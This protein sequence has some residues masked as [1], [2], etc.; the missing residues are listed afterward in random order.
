MNHYELIDTIG[1]GTYGVV[2]KCRDKRTGRIVAVKQFKNFQTNAYIRCTMLR[3]LRV[4]QLLKGEPNVTQ[5]LETFK[6]R[7]RL[8]LVMEYIPRSLL[9][10]LEEFRNGVP[11]GPLMV[12]L[13]TILLGIQ[14][15][16]RNGIIHRDV[17]PE[18]I[19]VRDDGTAS[20]CDFGFCR[21]ALQ[22]LGKD[23]DKTAQS[24]GK[25]DTKRSSSSGVEPASL[26][27]LHARAASPSAQS[28]AASA[29]LN[30]LVLADHRGVMTDYVATRWYRSPEML[31]GMP[32]YSYSVDMWAVGAIMAEVIDGEPL[33]PGK[34]ELEQIALIQSRIGE[35]PASYEAAV[36]RRNGG[37]LHLRSSNPL[38]KQQSQAP[39]RG[40]VRLGSDESAKGTA[41]DDDSNTISSYL[42]MRYGGR[43]RK[44]GMQLLSRLLCVDSE[45]RLTVEEAL[46]H[47]Y[48]DAVRR[49][50][51]F[52]APTSGPTAPAAVKSPTTKRREATGEATATFTRPS[53]TS[54]SVDALPGLSPTLRTTASLQHNFSSTGRGSFLTAAEASMGRPPR[55]AEVDPLAESGAPEVSSL[56]SRAAS[57]S[58]WQFGGSS[59]GFVALPPLDTDDDTAASTRLMSQVLRIDDSKED[60]SGG[61]D[62]NSPPPRPVPFETPAKEGGQAQ[63]RRHA[64]SEGASGTAAACGKSATSITNDSSTSGAE[65]RVSTLLFKTR[66]ARGPADGGVLHRR[67]SQSEES[68]LGKSVAAPHASNGAA[69]AGALAPLRTHRSDGDGERRPPPSV[70][71]YPSPSLPAPATSSSKLASIEKTQTHNGGHLTQSAQL[72]FDK[73]HVAHGGEAS[74]EAAGV[75]ASAPRSGGDGDTNAV[76]GPQHKRTNSYTEQ[77]TLRHTAAVPVRKSTAKRRRPGIGPSPRSTTPQN[78]ITKHSAAAAPATATGLPTS[79]GADQA[80]TV[81]SPSATRMR[82]A[83]PSR[84]NASL[85]RSQNGAVT[86]PSARHATRKVT[87]RKRS[88]GGTAATTPTT[89]AAAAQGKSAKRVSATDSSRFAS[90]KLPRVVKPLQPRERMT[91][92]KEIESLGG[93]VD[94]P[95]AVEVMLPTRFSPTRTDA[96]RAEEAEQGSA[97]PSTSGSRSASVDTAEDH[98]ELAAATLQSLLSEDSG[99]LFVESVGGDS[100]SRSPLLSEASEVEAA[101]R[102]PLTPAFKR[103]ERGESHRIAQTADNAPSHSRPPRMDFG[104]PVNAASTTSGDNSNSSRAPP[105]LFFRPSRNA[106]APLKLGAAAYGGQST[107]TPQSLPLPTA[108]TGGAGASASTDAATSSSAYYVGG[109]STNALMQPPNTPSA[110]PTLGQRPT[111]T[112]FRYPPSKSSTTEPSPPF[113]PLDVPAAAT[114]GRRGS[115]QPPLSGPHSTPSR[116]PYDSPRIPVTT[117]VPHHRIHASYLS[118]GTPRESAED[119]AASQAG[120][121]IGAPVP[122]PQRRLSTTHL[123]LSVSGEFALGVGA[124]SAASALAQ[125][126]RSQEHLPL[127]IVPSHS[128]PAV[129]VD[130]LETEVL[131]ST[132]LDRALSQQQ[133]AAPGSRSLPGAPTPSPSPPRSDSTAMRL[134]NATR[135]ASPLMSTPLRSTARDVSATPQRGGSGTRAASVAD[136]TRLRTPSL[137]TTPLTR[138]DK[139]GGSG[140]ASS[141]ERP[142]LANAVSLGE[143][144]ELLGGAQT[145]SFPLPSS[146]DRS[147]PHGDVVPTVREVPAAGHTPHPVLGGVWVNVDPQRNNQSLHGGLTRKKGRLIL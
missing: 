121:P 122:P 85:T 90:P 20:L 111:P 36:R 82:K 137:R 106:N 30:E 53:A 54:V 109:A 39:L 120:N 71:R 72:S 1:E 86:S 101:H 46:A 94:T 10:V 13:Y 19:L 88:S 98:V 134:S 28:A 69:P 104:Y 131:V 32:S 24:E 139:S 59:H 29:L 129:S 58:T 81:T 22:P 40:R 97:S 116:T 87:P 5:L 133:P 62:G 56:L 127:L 21:P 35:F 105:S 66:K 33:L 68:L 108:F 135:E 43:I 41:S 96:V 11:E 74:E 34:T 92:L 107:T 18:N 31:L 45:G 9:D 103:E 50:P 16:H 130:D 65:A 115:L 44:S 55:A 138:A 12:L 17:K 80:E 73:I 145:V 38:A 143:E 14:S 23:G 7:N 60:G 102:S 8:Y 49:D 64:A 93:P 125:S 91:L 132:P 114:E 77:P 25:S 144:D 67:S 128:P 83:S 112:L 124:G 84:R 141:R 51:R 4:E 3:E 42:S 100:V 126:Q 6:Q 95:S 136:L 117:S 110:V 75:F 52:A 118:A 26:S 57:V 146:G 123:S 79:S 119:A 2:Y 48:F 89:A 63:S 142:Q 61:D 70:S 140:T 47:P 99:N 76:A 37:M 147:E 27:A 113:M 78:N 15:C